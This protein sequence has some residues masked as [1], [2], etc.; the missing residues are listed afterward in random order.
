VAMLP[1]RAMALLPWIVSWW[2]SGNGA[3]ARAWP[4]SASRL[5]S[6]GLAG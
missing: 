4:A 6:G 2:L 5:M 1:L 3:T